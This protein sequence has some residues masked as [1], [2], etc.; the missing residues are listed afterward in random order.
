MSVAV[1][2]SFATCDDSRGEI[3]QYPR[4]DCLNGIDEWSGEEEFDEGVFGFRMI[5]EGEE[6]PMN[7]PSSCV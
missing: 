5:E 6:T 3:S 2:V 4:A 1:L 7:K